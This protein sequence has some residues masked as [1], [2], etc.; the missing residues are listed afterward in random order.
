MTRGLK[1]TVIVLCIVGVAAPLAL[2]SNGVS[3]E[4]QALNLKVGEV[5]LSG[6]P[7]DGVS[8]GDSFDVAVHVLLEG[9]AGLLDDPIVQVSL[10]RQDKP[11]A[12]VTEL[13]VVP[14]LD[15]EG[16]GSATVALRIATT[17]LSGGRYEVMALV[18]YDGPETERVDNLRS[19]GFVTINDPRP[20]L[21]P[22]A[23]RVEPSVPLR[24][25]ETVT[26]EATVANTGRLAAAAFR[27]VF[28][29]CGRAT[30]CDDCAP[31]TDV[32]DD[33]QPS[34]PCQDDEWTE[35]ASRHVA[36]LAR[37]EELT[38]YAPL[39]SATLTAIGEGSRD[40]R[41]RVVYPVE[42]TDAGDVIAELDPGN[43]EM[44]T[45][46]CI[47]PSTLGRPDLVPVSIT[48]NEDLPLGWRDIMDATVIVANVGGKDARNGFSVKFE[49]RSVG[50][51][52]WESLG[53]QDV[54]AEL[55]VEENANQRAVQVEI[56]PQG[57]DPQLEPGSYELR[58]TVGS[59]DGEREINTTNNSLVVGFS[60]RGTELQVEGLELPSAPVRQGDTVV[61]TSWIVNTGDRPAE[62][63][64][65]GFYL[66]GER[67]DTFLYLADS[68]G[69]GLKEDQSTQVQGVLSTRDLPPSVY[70]LRVVVDPDDRIPEYD[71]ANNVAIGRVWVED[72]AERRAELHFTSLRLEPASP[73]PANSMIVCSLVARNSGEIDSGYV[74]VVLEYAK[75]NAD[76][77]SEALTWAP[78]L[79]SSGGSV[80]RLLTGLER[81]ESR[82]I[83]L[84]FSTIGLSRGTYVLRASLDREE[85]VLEMDEMNNELRI[86]FSV[87]E[88]DV[89]TVE[90]INLVC[91][92]ITANDASEDATVIHGWIL[93]N[94]VEDA[95]GFQV[96]FSVVDPTGGEQQ[97]TIRTYAGLG[98][99]ESAEYTYTV[100][101]AGMPPGVVYATI[102]V[103]SGGEVAE[104][105][106]T[107]NVCT[108]SVLVGIT[109]PFSNLV[110]TGLRFSPPCS[111]P[112]SDPG[113]A[114]EIG[115]R[116]VA[117]ATVRN[118]GNVA[119]GAFALTFTASGTDGTLTDSQ[120]VSWA[121]LGAME[122]AEVSYL[123]DT[124][125]P[126][127]FALSVV[128]DSDGAIPETD[129]TDNELSE[130]FVVEGQS[131]IVATSLSSRAGVSA[132]YLAVD[133]STDTLY[134][135]WSDGVLQAIGQDGA[136]S[137]VYDAGASI[138][139]MAHSLGSRG[140][141]YLGVG[142][143][144][145]AA[146]LSAGSSQAS[147]SLGD[148]VTA[149]AVAGAGRLFAAAGKTVY[150]LGPS[151]QEIT[152]LPFA[153]DVNDIV[154]D[155][156]RD[157]LYITTDDGLFAADAALDP[158]CEATAFL[159]RSTALAI[160]A[161]GVFVGTSEGYVYALS[162]CMM[163]GSSAPMMVDGWRYRF[164]DGSSGGV[165]SIQADLDALRPIIVSIGDGSTGAIAALTYDGQLQWLYPAE[166]SAPSSDGLAFSELAVEG[167]SGRVFFLDA[168]GAPRL[169]ESD[170]DIAFAIVS[171][172]ASPAS[173]QIAMDEY[174]R[175]VESGSRLVRAYYYG[176]GDSVYRIESER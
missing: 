67:F 10:R 22:V 167:R 58:A 90:G 102:Y 73:V 31:C 136:S 120:R 57:E 170:G 122:A 85:A 175:I 5:S 65:V 162:F 146:E 127:E 150:L 32:A 19:A 176:A 98:A 157:T 76:C 158:L 63:F 163:H 45:M 145:H 64:T 144:V 72:P 49:W 26:L 152:R 4:A 44:R 125:V 61:V 21:H 168:A 143:A 50:A 164:G 147:A 69:D 38:V 13:T 3:A 110:M 114:V 16:S 34:G 87:D 126:G 91:R 92:D 25:G 153:S 113:M 86:A 148:T 33:G 105:N 124:S 42:E 142:E 118:E 81:G 37:N 151:L 28:E 6:V 169:L 59:L 128:A 123:V 55:P 83:R 82:E 121:G 35:I 62:E 11:E 107:D 96:R 166:G 99:G 139:A 51:F 46:L 66:N 133:P 80:A 14:K 137:S 17:S 103:D 27:V 24:E 77:S 47:E 129:E 156:D 119:V 155:T 134:A 117:F 7:A 173:L 130:G 53:S 101:K 2:G 88:S 56:N 18:E 116:L 159:G 140:T 165:F 149:I 108:A 39:D 89:G 171:D 112:C 160:G 9:G 75:C 106:E 109:D 43:N 20:E 74:D 1:A 78:L 15:L 52:Q 97:Q 8:S 111:P 94:G 29:T 40:V 36:G 93:N 161:T 135:A 41:V 79:D 23:F 154:Y 95:G 104:T 138:G 30:L 70:D 131:D 174:R 141:V 71:E 54:S 12:C 68:T 48:F 132:R 172:G 84:P 60:I 115:E 100:S